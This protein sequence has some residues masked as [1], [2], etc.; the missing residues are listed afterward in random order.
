MHRSKLLEIIRAFDKETLSEC[1]LFLK[2]QYLHSKSSKEHNQKL[3]EWLLNF[4]PDFDD[5]RLSKEATFQAIFPNKTYKSGRIEKI[6][7]SLVKA[8]YRFLAYQTIKKEEDQIEFQ[9]KQ[10]LFFRNKNLEKPYLKLV[11]KLKTKQQLRKAD[12]EDFYYRNYL[13]QKELSYYAALNNSRTESLNIPFTIRSLDIFYLVKKLEYSCWLL[14]QNQNRTSGDEINVL[15]STEAMISG[16]TP[17]ILDT[18]PLIKAYTLAYELLKSNSES[19]FHNLQNHLED[20]ESKIPF[21]KIKAFQTLCRNYCITTYNANETEALLKITFDLYRTHLNKGYLFYDGGLLPSTI[22][23]LVLKGLTL[24]EHQWVFE[25]LQ[26]AKDKIIGTNHPQDVYHFNMAW[27]YFSLKKYEAALALLSDSYEDVYYKVTAKRL[28]I[29]IRF[30]QRSILTDT[31]LDAFKIYIFRLGKKALSKLQKEANNNFADIMKQVVNP[32]TQNN[33]ARIQKLIAKVD[34]A[35]VLAEK[36]WL[37]E[38]LSAL[39]K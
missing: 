30:E 11:N 15:E 12:D 18:E 36:V 25:F 27:Y 28:E 6:M 16:I 24:N 32:K 39:M 34:D 17:E 10:A 21:E 38:Q 33:N 31:R 19:A 4:S 23:N 7:T 5:E 1:H 37:H 3:F 8:L 2:S 9:L 35:K 29:M 26:Q 20:Y 14:A 13:I 22:K